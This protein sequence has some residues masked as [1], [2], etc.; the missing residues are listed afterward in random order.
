MAVQHSLPGESIR[1]KETMKKVSEVENIARRRFI[2]GAGGLTTAVSKGL[3]GGPA[4]DVSILGSIFPC[5]YESLVTLISA[6][7]KRG[8]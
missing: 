1:E 5:L 2:I 7:M 8:M 4:L 3:R 6:K